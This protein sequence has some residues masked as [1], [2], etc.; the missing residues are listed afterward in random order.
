M[1][2]GNLEVELQRELHFT[3]IAD[4]GGY[5]T[6]STGAESER[7]I[8][9]IRVREV[10]VVES[11][12]HFRAEL[13]PHAF[14]YW[15]DLE[16]AEVHI[17]EAGSVVSADSAIPELTGSRHS[18][19]ILIQPKSGA[20]VVRR[21]GARISYA[22]RTR[23]MRTSRQA[24]IGRGQLNGSACLNRD[25]GVDLPAAENVA[26]NSALAEILLAFA[27]RQLVSDKA[28]EALANVEHR[29]PSFCGIVVG[30]LWKC[31]TGQI[32]HVIG[33]IVAPGVARSVRHSLRGAT[34]E[35]HE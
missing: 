27:D 5:R 30:V 1:V 11:V 34:P 23:S 33:D 29:V 18:K 16:E 28:H 12:E 6:K 4:G 8:E 3:R 17:G 22:V 25:D 14:L 2:P 32:V 19:R 31:R 20:W 10:C 13:E 7:G 21:A 24:R 15:N 35:R 26:R 9:R